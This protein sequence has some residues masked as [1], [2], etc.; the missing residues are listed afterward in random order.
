MHQNKFQREGCEGN[1]L[2]KSVS[3][4]NERVTRLQSDKKTTGPPL[5]VRPVPP[6]PC[7]KR[8]RLVGKFKLQRKIFY[9]IG[10][11]MRVNTPRGQANRDPVFD[12]RLRPGKL[13]TAL[14]TLRRAQPTLPITWSNQSHGYGFSN[15][16][17]CV[18]ASGQYHTE[19]PL[20]T[21]RAQGK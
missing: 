5:I 14:C 13:R 15:K 7:A 19:T 4:L 1:K 11:M 6:R 10:F 16:L 9:F 21:L 20:R 12:L 2:I 17:A 3:L 8:F 18:G